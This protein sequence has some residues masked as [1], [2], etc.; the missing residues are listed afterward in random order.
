[1]AAPYRLMLLTAT[2][3]PPVGEGYVHEAKVDG[4]PGFWEL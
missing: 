3:A 4:S 1:M 2:P